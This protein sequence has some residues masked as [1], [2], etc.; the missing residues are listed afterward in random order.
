MSSNIPHPTHDMYNSP[1]SSDHTD[2]VS[3]R[4]TSALR[5]RSLRQAEEEPHVNLARQSGTTSS[6]TSSSSVDCSAWP[7][8]AGL[9][10]LRHHPPGLRSHPTG[11]VGL[12]G[13]VPPVSSPQVPQP[14][15]RSQDWSSSRGHG[16]LRS[17]PRIQ[18]RTEPQ[19]GVSPPC[20][21][22]CCPPGCQHALPPL[23]RDRP[24]GPDRLHWQAQVGAGGL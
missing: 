7:P 24:G 6:V 1:Q 2:H 15:G 16:R 14:P 13:L 5:P 19:A 3:C 21:T 9:L 8:Y 22:P 23:H 20:P 11:Q 18:A 17:T 10:R 12:L 4:R